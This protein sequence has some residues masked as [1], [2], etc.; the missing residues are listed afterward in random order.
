MWRQHVIG[1]NP[2]LGFRDDRTI[3]E[4]NLVQPVH[5]VHDEAMLRSEMHKD[6]PEQ[7]RQTRFIHAQDLN[8][9]PGRIGQRPQ[10][11]EHGA[12]PHFLARRGAVLHRPVIERREQESDPHL[13]DAVGHAVWR[14]LDVYAQRG[15]HVG[16]PGFGRHRAIAVFGDGQ[17]GAGHDKRRGRR[18]VEGVA[19]VS[20]GPAGIHDQRIAHG[21]SDGTIAHGLHGPG[22]FLHRFA[23]EAQAHQVG[24]DL[25]RGR[26]P[27]HDLF[28]DRLG[29]LFSQREALGQFCDRVFNH[30]G[31]TASYDSLRK[32][33]SRSLPAVVRIDSG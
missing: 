12:D 9:R 6:L 30:H 28:H 27:V 7:V 14:E 33:R 2:A 22:D 31:K 23:L 13:I 5:P 25:G 24:R 1:Q 29:F 20:S 16:A 21:D 17:P 3:G 11:I 10:Q 32:F 8:G 18:N 15:K 19:P 26:S 4:R